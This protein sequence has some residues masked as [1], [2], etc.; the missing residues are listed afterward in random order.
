[1]IMD[2]NDIAEKSANQHIE[3]ASSDEKVLSDVLDTETLAYGPSGLRG[4]IASPYVLGAATLASL[5]GFSFGYGAYLKLEQL[6][7]SD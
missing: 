5:G 7:V 6:E 1:M 2:N 3:Q 4:I